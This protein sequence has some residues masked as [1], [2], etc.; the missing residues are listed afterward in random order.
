M[1]ARSSHRFR[2]PRESRAL[3]HRDPHLTRYHGVFAPASPDRA[4][5]VPRTRAAA[6]GKAVESGEPSASDGQRSLTWAQRLKRVFAIDIEVCRRC[7]GKLKV[8][9]SIEDPPG[10]PA[11]PRARGRTS[12]AR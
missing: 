11:S 5:V 10:S 1:R 6:A 2:E 12:R 9:A 7:G 4:R 3:P 8:I